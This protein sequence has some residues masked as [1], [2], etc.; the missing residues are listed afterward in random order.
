MGPILEAFGKFAFH[1]ESEALF[2]TL[3]NPAKAQKRMRRLGDQLAK[4]IA[5]ALCLKVIIH[6][7]CHEYKM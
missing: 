6:P 2:Y 5:V 3:I 4:G 7:Q 1:S